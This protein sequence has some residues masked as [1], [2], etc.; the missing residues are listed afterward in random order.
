MTDI[1]F[2]PATRLS[3]LIRQ[4]KIGCLELLEHYISRV[5]KYNPAINAVVVTDLPNAR[6][7]ARAADK[8]LKNG[9]VWGPFHGIPMTV[10][11]SF[12]IA[13]LPTT[14]GVPAFK[15]VSRTKNALAVDR[16]LSSGAVIFGK[17]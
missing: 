11:E 14:W 4:K 7:R 16:W 8:A 6:K 9:E 17:T 2:S 5:E 10:K 3:R 1:A 13:G 12:Q 15:D